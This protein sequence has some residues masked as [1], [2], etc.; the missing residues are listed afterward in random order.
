MKE[1]CVLVVTALLLCA[2]VLPA[3]AL[4]LSGDAGEPIT[5]VAN[6][7]NGGRVAM[8]KGALFFVN[9]DRYL[10][11]CSPPFQKSERA[12]GAVE[13]ACLDTL[14][15][16]IYYFHHYL[17]EKGQRPSYFTIVGR[18]QYYDPGK[19]PKYVT[20]VVRDSIRQKGRTALVH[21]TEK[22]RS[23]SV[24]QDAV[25]YVL[26]NS[27]VKTDISGKRTQEIPIYY[28]GQAM[29]VHYVFP[30]SGYAYFNGKNDGLLYRVPLSG[31]QAERLSE[32]QVGGFT[33]AKKGAQ[34]VLLFSDAKSNLY[35]WPLDGSSAPQVM[36]GISASALNADENYAYFTNAA[37]GHKV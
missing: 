23:L 10:M 15:N 20:R 7:V 14:N 12:Y 4:M 5:G 29:D 22:I 28:Q 11:E 8:G 37:N 21:V 25:Y 17:A 35:S 19:P 1:H 34:D 3:F 2:M 18:G 9:K 30:Y 31:Q 24:T 16:D 6:A 36:E 33:I 26:M 32:Q 27:L 13:Y